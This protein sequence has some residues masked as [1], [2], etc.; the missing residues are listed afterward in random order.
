MKIPFL[1]KKLVV[2]VSNDVKEIEALQ[3]W[4]VR[5][6]SRHGEYSHSTRREIEVFASEQDAQHFAAALQAAFR[7]I[8]ITTENEVRV[9]KTQPQN[10]TAE[11]DG[12][13]KA[14]SR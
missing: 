8:R 7:L 9:T 10:L 6:T 4:E 2:P 11:I 1:T 3:T 13:L 14:H 5:W 12:L